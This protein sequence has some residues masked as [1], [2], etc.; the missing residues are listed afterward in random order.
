M[1]FAQFGF[2]RHQWEALAEALKF[3]AR[4]NLVEQ[5]VESEYG[6][7]YTVVGPLYTPSGRRPMVAAVWVIETESE[8]PRLV[9]AY[10]AKKVEDDQGT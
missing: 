6:A 7:R 8:I 1:F 2:A 3:H 10:P 9:T 5:V 4:N